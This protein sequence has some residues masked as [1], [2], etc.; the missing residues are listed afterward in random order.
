M[1]D[2]DP[3]TVIARETRHAIAKRSMNEAT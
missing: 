3:N 1:K 2:Y